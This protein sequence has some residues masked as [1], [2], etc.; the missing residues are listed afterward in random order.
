MPNF[1]LESLIDSTTY[2]TFSVQLSLLRAQALN[3]A[4]R[5]V[6]VSEFRREI[7]ISVSSKHFYLM[8]LKYTIF[9]WTWSLISLTLHWKLHKENF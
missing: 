5:S 1:E 4:L 8:L 7:Q 3:L 9:K 6:F 2:I